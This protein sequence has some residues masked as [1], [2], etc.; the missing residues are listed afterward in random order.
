VVKES[1]EFVDGGGRK[2]SCSAEQ[3]RKSSPE[4][5]WWFRVSSERHQRYAPF[6]ASAGDTHRNVQSRIIAYYDDLL[7]RRAMPAT[8]YYRRNAPAAAAAPAA[9]AATA[10]AD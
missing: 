7:A 6:R 8:S 2:F 9:P 3:M 1:F 10:S 5:W 4:K